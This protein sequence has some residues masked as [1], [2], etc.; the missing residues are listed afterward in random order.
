[1]NTE[2]NK[3]ETK[4][5]IAKVMARAG[6]CSRRDAEVW[7][8][9]GRVILNGTQ[10]DSP[11]IT[12]GPEDEIMVD[13]KI[14]PQ[15][16]DVRLWLYHKPRGLITTHKDPEGRPTVFDNLPRDMPRVISVGRLDVNSEGLLLLTNS[17]TLSRFFE[18]PQTQIPRIYRVRVFGKVDRTLPQQVQRG[19]T[20]EGI[21]YGPMTL[22][23]EESQGANTWLNLTLYEGKNREI[24]RIIQHFGL[25]LSRLIRV[26]Y[27]PFNLATLA[28][29]QGWEVPTRRLKADLTDLGYFGGS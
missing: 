10:L 3:T 6:L 9:A 2:E 8:R 24:R 20:I 4:E 18:H 23:V 27:G 19:L 14:L 15:E 1:M 5:R 26:S 22:T 28:P 17:G 16:D 11:A 12:V 29:H 7:I 13:G 25:S 21:Y